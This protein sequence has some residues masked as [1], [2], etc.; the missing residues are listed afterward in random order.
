MPFKN[1]LIILAFAAV[2]FTTCT[3]LDL[4][5]KVPH[6]VEIQ[7]RKIKKEP[8]NNP[9]SQV[10]EW[11]VDNNTFYYITSGCCDQFNYLYNVDCNKVCAP[12]GG[13]TGGGDGNC[14][15]FVGNIEKTLVWEDDRKQ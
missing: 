9:P 2:L 8:V 10:W 11:K 12:D 5:K 13:L 14:P 1:N 4:K 7:I 15:E 6:C 3:K